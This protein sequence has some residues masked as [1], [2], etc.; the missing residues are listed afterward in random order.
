[1]PQPQVSQQH[2]VLSWRWSPIPCRHAAT[3]CTPQADAS[4]TVPGVRKKPCHTMYELPRSER[5]LAHGVWIWRNHT[6]HLQ[7][8]ALSAAS[9]SCTLDKQETG[10]VK[11]SPVAR[12]LQRHRPARQR[13]IEMNKAVSCDRML[14]GPAPWR[15]LHK[16]ASA[17]AAPHHHRTQLLQH[18]KVPPAT[19]GRDSSPL[20][21]HDA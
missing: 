10:L 12:E 8:S 17:S 11:R 7:R 3:D 9:S 5:P 2:L 18:S 20:S 16:P 6:S 14:W 19:L 4:P 15:R 1:M 21:G 13:N